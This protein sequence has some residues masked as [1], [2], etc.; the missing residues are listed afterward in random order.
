MDEYV[1]AGVRLY[2]ESF[3]IDSVLPLVNKKIG[4]I[5]SRVSDSRNMLAY[6]Q[7]ADKCSD[8]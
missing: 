1:T 2:S 3:S 7:W 8:T 4:H 6:W 5:M